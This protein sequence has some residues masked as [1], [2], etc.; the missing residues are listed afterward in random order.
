[1]MLVSNVLL[2]IL[3]DLNLKKLIVL[4]KSNDKNKKTIPL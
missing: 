4:N 3:L 2:S 1:M